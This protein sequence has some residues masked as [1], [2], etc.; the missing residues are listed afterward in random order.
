ML[1]MLLDITERKRLEEQLRE[2]HKMEGIGRLAG[3]V[4]HEFNNILAAIMLNL[5]LAKKH[6]PPGESLELLGEIDMLSHRAA[7]LIKRLLIFSRRSN[8]KLQQMDWV[9]STSKQ[10]DMLS[11][12]LGEGFTLTLHK[13]AKPLWV[14]ADQTLLE[15]LLLDLCLNAR[16]A[17][18][19]G[20]RLEISLDEVVISP[21][22]AQFHEGALAGSYVRL[23]VADTGR[24]INAPTMQRLFE[25]FFTTKEI[26]Q[27]TGL[28]LAAVRG[29]VQQHQGWVQVESKI[30][31]GSTFKVHLPAVTR[32][33][34]S[35]PRSQKS[36]AAVGQSV[37]LIV[38]DEPT[39][40]MA[41]RLFLTRAGYQ[42][43][44]AASGA[45]ALVIWKQHSAEIQLIYT[46]MVMPGATSGVQ[47]A[48]HALAEKPGLKVV[49]TSGYNTDTEELRKVSPDSIIYLAKPC[50][51]DRL[52]A[53]I[54]SCFPASSEAA[55]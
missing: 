28:G 41:T 54:Q 40:R 12:L 5:C 36:N 25:P 4:A 34:S 37:I 47:L 1:G 3:G 24:G 38:E 19:D 32:R 10:C 29:I 27:G 20:G 7:E 8:L 35:A 50:P 16:D 33:P 45:E 51:P 44:E 52:L 9:A 23:S 6:C 48:Q 55:E 46:D 26:G 14:Q 31:Q 21:E 53:T 2:A 43:L 17:M 30:G 11:R 13:P 39:I 49:I 15:Q 42:V 22:E 18:R